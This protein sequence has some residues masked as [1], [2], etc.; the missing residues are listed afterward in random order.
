MRARVRSTMCLK[1]LLEL[2][3]PLEQQVPV[4][5][6]LIHRVGVVEAGSLLVV[7]AQSETGIPSRSSARIPRLWK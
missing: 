5:L 2:T 1:D 4:V 7:D 3:A 6:D